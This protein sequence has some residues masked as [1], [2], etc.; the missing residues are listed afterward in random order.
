[1]TMTKPRPETF[2]IAAYNGDIYEATRTSRDEPWT[3]TFPT[4][5]TRFHGSRA[6]AT[7]EIVRLIEEHKTA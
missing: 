6:E 2:Q 4:G 1:M 7:R 3:I 5:E